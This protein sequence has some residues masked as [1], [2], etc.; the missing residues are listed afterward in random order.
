MYQIV[1]AA[2]TKGPDTIAELVTLL[3]EPDCAKWLAHQLIEKA[4]TTRDIK[5]KCFFIVEALAKE[6][7]ADALGER[8]WLKEHRGH[9]NR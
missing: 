8:M 6:D 3:D 7:S 4:A 9:E 2:N 5:S 1:E